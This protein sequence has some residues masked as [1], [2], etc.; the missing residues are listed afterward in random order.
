[1]VEGHNERLDLP[2]EVWSKQIIAEALDR[3]GTGV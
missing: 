1:M 2:P 3:S